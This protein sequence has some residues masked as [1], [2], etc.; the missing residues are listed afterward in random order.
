[1]YVCIHIY[2]YMYMFIVD[3]GNLLM[4][5]FILSYRSHCYRLVEVVPR[6]NYLI[7]AIKS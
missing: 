4:A 7:L 1:M 6:L 5:V 2:I 3:H